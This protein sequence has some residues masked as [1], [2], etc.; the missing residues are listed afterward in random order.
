MWSVAFILHI[1]QSQMMN[2]DLQLILGKCTNVAYLDDGKKKKKQIKALL[3][4]VINPTL[5]RFSVPMFFLDSSFH[6]TIISL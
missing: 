1:N 6:R 3:L 4:P 2:G 5:A